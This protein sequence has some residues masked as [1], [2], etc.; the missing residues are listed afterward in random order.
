MV[1]ARSLNLGVGDIKCGPAKCVL[2]KLNIVT[3]R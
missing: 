3:I 1:A 2:G